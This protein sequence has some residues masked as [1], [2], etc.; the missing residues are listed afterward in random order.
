MGKIP[1]KFQFLMIKFVNC[2][3]VSCYS[4]PE[5]VRESSRAYQGILLLIQTLL[6]IANYLPSESAS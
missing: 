6:S 4:H 2:F 5:L 1:N 3:I